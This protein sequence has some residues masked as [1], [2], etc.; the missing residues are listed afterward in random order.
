[1]DCG[2]V[3]IL[4][5]TGSVGRALVDGWPLAER[6]RLR[7]LLHRSR[8]DWLASG[9]VETCR[10]DP[11][12]VADLR[13]AL[14]GATAL[15]DLLRPTGDGWRLTAA[16]RLFAIGTLLQQTAPRCRAGDRVDGRPRQGDRSVDDGPV[17]RRIEPS[18]RRGKE[19]G[20]LG[21]RFGLGGPA[22]PSQDGAHG[23]PLAVS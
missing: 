21:L 14:D 5:G 2:R 18:D 1:M 7:V 6:Q 4:G 8:P 23:V 22:G 9:D 16:A 12:S 11:T 17:G 15:I 13:R 3:V 19:P 20:G 10:I